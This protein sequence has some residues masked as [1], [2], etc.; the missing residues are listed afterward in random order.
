MP[1]HRLAYRCWSVA[2]FASWALAASGAC[3]LV[4]AVAWSA[5]GIRRIDDDV[6]LLGFLI[7]AVLGLVAARATRQRRG[8]H[9]A[10]LAGG[11][12]AIAAGTAGAVKMFAAAESR[13][14]H[15]PFAGLGEALVGLVLVAVA[16]IGVAGL[17]AGAFGWLAARSAA[18]EA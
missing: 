3:G 18:R 2:Y 8:V 14:G 13:H 1:G 16:A 9:R 15:G 10:L 5:S 6:V 7:G 4:S 12:V 11:L 17:A